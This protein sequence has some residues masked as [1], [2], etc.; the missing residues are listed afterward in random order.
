[1]NR[2]VFTYTKIYGIM[3]L[4]QSKHMIQTADFTEY[5]IA[6]ELAC[7]ACIGELLWR[8]K[9]EEDTPEHV[10][11]VRSY[12]CVKLVRSVS[13][14]VSVLVPNYLCLFHINCPISNRLGLQ[15]IV[16]GGVSPTSQTLLSGVR[17][18]ESPKTQTK[19]ILG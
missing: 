14:S 3:N 8:S 2:R 13:I 15:R 5:A 17:I 11:Q 12:N 6:L 7:G 10:K 16:T 4:V 19:M 18:V 1:M 9:F